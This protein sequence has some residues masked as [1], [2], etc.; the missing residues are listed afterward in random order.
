RGCGSA[1]PRDL[2]AAAS[3]VPHL[4][5]DADDDR[6]AVPR[7]RRRAAVLGFVRGS[8]AGMITVNALGRAA[9]AAGLGALVGAGWVALFYAWHPAF[10]IEF[11]RDF[12]R[13]VSGIYGPERDEA[14]GLT[15]AWT[16]DDAV[17]RLPGLD[18]RVPWTL[19]VRARGGRPAPAANP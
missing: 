13:N 15:F 3:A 5:R 16:S 10:T 17:V 19:T 9:A 2:R 12:P 1:R 7:R 14:T 4:A 18:R 6:T 8:D 11:D